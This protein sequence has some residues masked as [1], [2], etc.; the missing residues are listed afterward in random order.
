MSAIDGRVAADEPRPSRKKR[1]EGL[2]RLRERGLGVLLRL[3]LHLVV[4]VGGR[5]L[6]RVLREAERRV[7]GARDERVQGADQ[8]EHRAVDHR[9]LAGSV[10]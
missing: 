5:D 9:P 4:G 10:G 2:E 1:A 7:G 6:A 3:R 8:V